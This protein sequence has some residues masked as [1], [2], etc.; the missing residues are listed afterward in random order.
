MKQEWP[1]M[2]LRSL[3]SLYSD[4]LPFLPQCCKTLTALCCTLG[5]HFLKLWFLI[6]LCLAICLRFVGAVALG[7]IYVSSVWCCAKR[8][9]MENAKLVNSKKLSITKAKRAIDSKNPLMATILISLAANKWCV[10]RIV[11]LTFSCCFFCAIGIHS[12]DRYNFPF[13]CNSSTCVYYCEHKRK[14]KVWARGS[15]Y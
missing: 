7:T 6:T 15:W 9:L 2:L 8:W 10:V 13:S 5:L 12:H 14:V 3:H 1:N 11:G 4:S